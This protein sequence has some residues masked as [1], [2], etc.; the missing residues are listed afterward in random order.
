[1]TITMQNAE[2]LTLTE[3]QEFV[4]GSRAL[5]WTAR[6]RA[7]IY[8]FLRRVLEAQQ[9]ARLRKSEKGVVRL[10]LG[11]LTGLSRAQLTRLI[12]QWNRRGRIEVRPVRRHCFP[13]HYTRQDIALLAAV[14]TA[15]EGLSG[16]AVRRILQRE[17][18]VFGQAEFQRLAGISASHLYN[19]RRAGAYRRQR[20]VLCHTR[21]RQVP[22][23]ERRKPDP[24]GQPGYLRVD[25]VHQGHHDGQPGLYHLNAVDTVTQWQVVG[26]TET[27]SER[28]LVPVLEAIL[29]QFPFRILG[30]HC[31][32]GSEFLNYTVA[33]LLNKLLAEF[34]K[35]RPYRTT[36]NA[37][38][39]GKNGAVVR[40]HIGYGP[41]AAGQ[42]AA[43]QKFYTA[44]FNPYLNY[45]RPCGFATVQ[46]TARGQRKRRYRPDDYR[47]P[48]E[49][50]LSLPRWEQFLK[51]GVTAALLDAHATRRSDTEAARQMQRAKAT[52]LTRCQQQRA[53]RNLSPPGGSRPISGEL[54]QGKRAAAPLPRTPIPRSTQP[55]PHKK[56]ESRQQ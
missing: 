28:H 11:K 12:G 7:A 33:R 27:I 13:V 29:H 8:E 51:P 17:Y 22:I 14:D 10:F 53:Y 32:N 31:D 40:K 2:R 4:A 26:A 18:H 44:W 55:Q 35:S 54:M 50:L 20:I 49:K 6:G 41:L 23:G 45:H 5:Q 42:A 56:G 25:T 21:A 37:L 16:P 48:Y 47:T 3:M 9:Y 15:H 24:H 38:V 30:F 43:L 52:V 1:M 36:D 39:E 46:I 19:L 34:T